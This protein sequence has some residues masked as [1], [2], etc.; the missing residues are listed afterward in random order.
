MCLGDE[1]IFSGNP[2]AFHDG[3]VLAQIPSPKDVLGVLIVMTGVAI[4]KPAFDS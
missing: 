4:H 2:I 1:A 3:I